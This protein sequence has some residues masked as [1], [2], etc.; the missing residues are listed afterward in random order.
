MQ[1]VAHCNNTLSPDVPFDFYSGQLAPNGKIYVNGG[2]SV[3]SY[4]V[5]EEPDSPGI[6][7]HVVQDLRLPAYTTGF[8]YYPNYRLSSASCGNNIDS[9]DTNHV[10]IVY[11]AGTENIIV[12]IYPNPAKDEVYVN[13]SGNISDKLTLEWYDLLGR[14]VQTNELKTDGSFH[15]QNIVQ[16]GNLSNGMY[17]LDLRD[18]GNRLFSGKLIISK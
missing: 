9:V 15:S 1:V 3:Y 8:P 18:N 12:G 6:A 11:V 17:M 10:G 5:I 14:L 13:I 7:C 16:I 2:S 4:S